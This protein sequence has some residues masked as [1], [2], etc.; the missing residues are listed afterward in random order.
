MKK[1]GLFGGTFDP[2]HKGHIKIAELFVTKIEL[3]I[4]Y[5]IPAKNSPFKIANPKMFSDEE[6]CQ[7][8]EQMILTNPKFQLCK[9]ELEN[10]EI[11]YTVDTVR[12]FKN[13]FVEAEL[14]LLV[15]SDQSI[16]FHLWK[17]YEKILELVCVVI[18]TRPE[19]ITN[20]EQ[21][22]IEKTFSNAKHLYLN[23][24]IFDITSTKI[25]QSHKQ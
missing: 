9:Y 4:C 22:Q 5:F 7:K 1:I 3:D 8:I 12:Y 21:K 14:F 15:G 13:K 18:A 6:R 19:K 17:E 16:N 2:V 10:S 23:N 24:P 20:E 11:S 25:R